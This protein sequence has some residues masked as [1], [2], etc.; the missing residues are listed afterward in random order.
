MNRLI[1]LSGVISLALTVAHI[2]PGGQ[3]VHVPV[4]ASSLD[5]TPKGYVSTV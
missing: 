5:E 2:G 1:A 3:E 4:L